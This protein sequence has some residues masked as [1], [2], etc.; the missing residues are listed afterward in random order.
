MKKILF[1]S[2]LII[3]PTLVFSQNLSENTAKLFIQSLISD[4]NNLQDFVDTTEIRL[5][6]RLDISYSDSKNKFLISNDLEYL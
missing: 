6:R 2:F 4:S 5:S 3:F 1:Y